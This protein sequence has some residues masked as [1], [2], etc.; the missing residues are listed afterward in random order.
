MHNAQAQFDYNTGLSRDLM[1]DYLVVENGQTRPFHEI[2]G[3]E[4]KTYNEV[5]NNRDPRMEQTFMKKSVVLPT[6]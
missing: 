3:Y 1:E 2:T 6:C 4:I 5:F